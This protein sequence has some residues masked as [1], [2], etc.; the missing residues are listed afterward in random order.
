MKI[1]YFAF[2]LQKK[3][4][5]SQKVQEVSEVLFVLYL[6]F[7]IPLPHKQLK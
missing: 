3:S 6:L 1:L 2:G 5:A 7:V 4:L